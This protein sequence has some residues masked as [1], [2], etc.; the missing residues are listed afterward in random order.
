MPEHE[1][2]T[3]CKR[4]SHSYHILYYSCFPSAH[5][6]SLSGT[7]IRLSLI[8]GEPSCYHQKSECAFCMSCVRLWS[9]VGYGSKKIYI[10]LRTKTEAK[11]CSNDS[12]LDLPENGGCWDRR[13]MPSVTVCNQLFFLLSQATSE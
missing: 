1:R 10:V 12:T 6:R 8:T 13:W 3:Q 7:R 4:I 11:F 2:F 5:E 9:Q